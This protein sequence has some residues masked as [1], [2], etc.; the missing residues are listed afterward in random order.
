AVAVRTPDGSNFL[1]NGG[2]RVWDWHNPGNLPDRHDVGE[3]TVAPF[4]LSR[5]TKTLDLVVAQSTEPQ[6]LGGLPYI[7][8][9]FAVERVVGPLQKE[10]FIP[11]R[12]QTYLNALG[13]EYYRSHSG[14][15]WFQNDYYGSWK[16]FW[17]P[18]KTREFPGGRSELKLKVLHPPANTNYEHHSS[19]NRSL[20]LSLKVG[21][22]FSMLL[23]GDI[24]GEAQKDLVKYYSKDTINHDVM[25]VPSNGTQKSSFREDFVRAVNP[26]KLIF[27]T[28]Y[29]DI[30]GPLAGKLSKQLSRNWSKARSM[31][32]GDNL[33]RT[34]RDY[35]IMLSVDT[36]DVVIETYADRVSEPETTGQLAL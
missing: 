16:R 36:E 27:S 23:P 7:L 13:D 2:R 34:D 24:R 3:R 11:L 1:L 21:P 25:L 5:R 4:Y 28:G 18:I 31:F 12:K 30:K 35:A 17:N 33:Y 8:K 19:S 26:N 20:V 15:S 14:S 9:Q 32:S 6:Y 22:D 29:P 10:K